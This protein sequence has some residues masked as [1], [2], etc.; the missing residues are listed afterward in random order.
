MKPAPRVVWG[1]WGLR[2]L[3]GQARGQPAR[4]GPAP[5]QRTRRAP[6]AVPE[7]SAGGQ[8]QQAV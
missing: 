2:V 8:V 1:L 7:A 3:E 5:E 4:E 6:W